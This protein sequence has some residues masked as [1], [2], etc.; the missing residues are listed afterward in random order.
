MN[1]R[2]SK[3]QS[4]FKV[5][6]TFNS[7]RPALSIA[8]APGQSM[9]KDYAPSRLSGMDSSRNLKNKALFRQVVKPLHDDWPE[10]TQF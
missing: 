3:A 8:F 10:A 7:Q 2:R 9:Q 1:G 4:W 5:S 6:G